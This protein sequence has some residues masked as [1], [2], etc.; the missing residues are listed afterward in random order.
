MFGERP[1]R[2]WVFGL[3]FRVDHA[4]VHE[5]VAHLVLFL[6]EATLLGDRP[7]LHAADVAQ[8]HDA[9]HA[10]RH[11]LL[12]YILLNMLYDLIRRLK[13]LLDGV[14]YLDVELLVHVHERC[15]ELALGEAGEVLGQAPGRV[16]IHELM[17]DVEV[18]LSHLLEILPV[19]V[20]RFD[21]EVGDVIEGQLELPDVDQREDGEAGQLQRVVYLDRGLLLVG[22]LFL[23]LA[24]LTV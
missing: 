6:R 12:D 2:F 13:L 11:A 8:L 17:P 9:G 14:L 4:V 1:F 20:G 18:L 24:Q 10:P 22:I 16:W 15:D 3:V 23:Y 7:L 19:A 21:K 5:V